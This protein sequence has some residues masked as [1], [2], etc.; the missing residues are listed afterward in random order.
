MS[1]PGDFSPGW[2]GLRE[3]ADA[4][5]R[6]RDLPRLLHETLRATARRTGTGV[7][8]DLGCGSGSMIRWLAPHLPGPQ[9]WVL[10]DLDPALLDLARTRAPRTGVDGAPV[11]VTTRTGDVG[12]LTGAEL[13]GAALVTATALLDLLT[14]AQVDALA[15]A[16]RDARA[17]ALL[18]LSVTGRVKPEPADPLDGAVEAAFN[19]H[20]RRPTPAGPLLGPDATAAAT[21]AFDRLGARVEV[22]ASPWDLGPDDAAL[23]EEWL[24]GW[25]DAAHRQRPDLGADLDAYRGRRLAEIAEDRVRVSVGHADLLARWDAG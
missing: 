15:S 14:T 4:R 5:A 6:S 13:A 24:R 19:D 3:A 7:G 11:T 18:A 16:C 22:R 2:L 10:H 8:H 12:D 20:Q 1:A 23:A 21:R 9:H 25:T 17:P